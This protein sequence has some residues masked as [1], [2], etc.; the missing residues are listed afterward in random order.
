M[1]DIV[2]LSL[3]LMLVA[4]VAGAGLSYVNDLT[5]PLIEKQIRQQKI[6]GFK[7]VYPEGDR[8]EDQS[9]RY[10]KEAHD[11][12]LREV[13]LAY[14]GGEPVGA[15]Y[16]VETKGYAGPISLLAGFDIASNKLIAVKVLSQRETPGLG[17]KAQERQF[18]DRYR[19]KGLRETLEVTKNAPVRENQIEAITAST[20]T[21]KAVTKGVN[22]ARAHFL[23]TFGP[24]KK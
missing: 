16:A 17:A 23:A 14:R 22:A 10:L 15:I 5:S 24:G 3:F 4:G 19:G 13:N 6:D 11:P 1:R 12:A 20:I 2:K 8:V 18:Q 21:S 7:E 9:Q